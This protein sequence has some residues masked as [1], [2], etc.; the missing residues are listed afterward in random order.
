MYIDSS[1]PNL[2]TDNEMS[3]VHVGPAIID[4][5]EGC[6]VAACTFLLTYNSQD[7]RLVEKNRQEI[8]SCVFI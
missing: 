7:W 6:C 3:G 1:Y 8:F 5:N 4:P 2:G